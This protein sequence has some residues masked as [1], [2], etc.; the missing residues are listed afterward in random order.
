VLVCGPEGMVV[1]ARNAVIDL[2]R[3]KKN[4]ELH[5]EVFHW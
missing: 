4:V 3:E 2:Q 5:E 1:E